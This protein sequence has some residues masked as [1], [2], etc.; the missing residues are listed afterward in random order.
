[1]NPEAKSFIPY[2][3]QCPTTEVLS[4][5]ELLVSLTSEKKYKAENVNLL[6]WIYDGNASVK[7][8]LLE[9]WFRN[10]LRYADVGD[11]G[12]KTRPAMRKIYK[13]TL[14][15]VNKASNNFPII[16]PY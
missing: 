9:E 16:L 6:L 4:I 2:Y 3:G 13:D 7:I 15:A 12:N 10:K 14:D 1:M 8:I 11:E 5:M